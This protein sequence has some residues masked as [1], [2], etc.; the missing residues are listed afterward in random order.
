MNAVYFD[1]R[2]DKTFV[3]RSM[4]VEVEELVVVLAEPGSEFMGHFAPQSGG[5]E[6]IFVDLLLSVASMTLI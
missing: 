3:E 6:D 5:S 1:G 2:K 4:N